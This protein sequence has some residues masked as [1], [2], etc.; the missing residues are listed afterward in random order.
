MNKYGQHNKAPTP[1]WRER[2]K[3]NASIAYSIKVG[4]VLEFITAVYRGRN[5]IFEFNSEQKVWKR[6]HKGIPFVK[7]GV[8]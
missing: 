8:A 5:P 3:V 2:K 7:V 6:T 1:S 4:D